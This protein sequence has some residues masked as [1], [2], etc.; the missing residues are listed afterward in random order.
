MNQLYI[1]PFH[2][3]DWV[4]KLS[5]FYKEPKDGQWRIWISSRH[6]TDVRFG[7]VESD[8][9]DRIIAEYGFYYYIR[10]HNSPNGPGKTVFLLGPAKVKKLMEIN[11]GIYEG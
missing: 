1:N 8:H 5:T 2:H 11:Q 10:C 6:A 3:P 9:I 7:T 4:I